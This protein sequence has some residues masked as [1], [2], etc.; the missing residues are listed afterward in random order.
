MTVVRVPVGVQRVEILRPR[1]LQVWRNNCETAA[2]SIL[3]GGAP[4]QR[5]LQDLLPIASPSRPRTTPQGL[6]WGDPQQGFV[7]DV[8]SG[9]YGV[10]ERP[11]LALATRVGASVVD[12]SGVPF[13]RL[14]D[15]VRSG[16][17]VLTW[18]TLGASSPQTWRTPQG[19][20]VQADRAEHAVVFVG[21]EAGRVIY[22]DPWDGTRKS[23][24]LE[25]FAARWR[26]LGRRA[27][28]LRLPL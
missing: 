19:N 11:I 23:E 10:Y 20:L 15:A 6:L 1:L 4:D 28:A 17:P 13:V 12:L 3:L 5:R 26:Q 18:V 27:V 14:V 8:R 16:R 22:L 21:W 7:G 2:L 25:T 24:D 9:G